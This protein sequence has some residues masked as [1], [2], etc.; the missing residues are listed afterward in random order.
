MQQKFIFGRVIDTGSWVHQLDPRSKMTAMALFAVIVVML[1]SLADFIVVTAVSQIIL[2]STRIKLTT[3]WRAVRPLKYLM[4]FIFL[5]QIFLES[6]GELLVSWGPIQIY[7]GG[8]ITAVFTVWRMFLFISFTALLTFTTAPAKLT[9]G[10]EDI[11][12]PLSIFGISAQKIALMLTIALRF[13]PTILEETQR[14]VKAQASRGADL[15]ELPWKD[16]AKTMIALLV[17]VTVCAFRRAEDLVN[18]ME[19]RGY[20][21]DAPRSKYF[22]LTWK[23]QD[24]LFLSIFVLLSVLI[25]FI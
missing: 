1:Q 20:Q 10:L 17:P 7:S 13:I 19:S 4:L 5:F 14:I 15:K 25:I 18:S 12:K 22:I 16:K 11:L 3:Y 6:G 23:T 24:S 21:L 8:I 9:Q 2:Y